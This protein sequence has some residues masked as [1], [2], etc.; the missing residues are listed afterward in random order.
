MIPEHDTVKSVELDGEIDTNSA[1]TACDIAGLCPYNTR[2]ITL[3][4]TEDFKTG[5]CVRYDY[6][7]KSMYK[8]HIA[9]P[10]EDMR[11]DGGWKNG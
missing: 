8:K 10:L 5:Y 7:P 2:S 4:L 3:V 6:P 1:I 11:I 9:E